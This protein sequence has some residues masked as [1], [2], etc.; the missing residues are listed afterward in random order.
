[1]P[2]HGTRRMSWTT[3]ALSPLGAKGVDVATNPAVLPAQFLALSENL[4]LDEGVAASRAGGRKL[5]RLVAAGASKTFGADT[6]YALIPAADQLVIPAGGFFLRASFTA[7]RGAGTTYLLGSR[8]NGQTFHVLSVT[9]TSAGAPVVTWRDSG[10]ST[11]TVTAAVVADGATVHLLAIYDAPAG[12]FTLYINGAS[13][14]TPLT[15]LASTLKPDQTASVVWSIGIEKESGAAVT[16]GS[17]FLGKID[18]LT[19]GSLA[20]TRP[21]ETRGD[22]TL[23]ATLVKWSRQQWPNPDADGLIFNYDLDGTS[24]TTL[25]DSSRFRNHAAVTGTPTDTAE[26]AYL[27]APAGIIAQHEGVD[28]SAFNVVEAGGVFAY[29]QLKIGV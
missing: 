24:L 23:A 3:T 8:P 17:G 21:S 10:G 27:A 13:S 14:G 16:A 11:R 26:V 22:S 29:Q 20:G 19:L 7:V 25:S 6:K 2:L 15:G 5:V 4:R 12:T 1:M 9:L 28:G 18:A